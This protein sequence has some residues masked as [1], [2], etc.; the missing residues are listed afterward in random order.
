MSAAPEARDPSEAAARPARDAAAG[1]E[2][3]RAKLLH[4]PLDPAA[5]PSLLP[6]PWDGLDWRLLAPYRTETKPRVYWAAD[7]PRRVVCK[8]ISAAWRRPFIGRFRR[9][10]LRNEVAALSALDGLPGLPRL[11]AH[12]P[13]GMACEFV[14]GR[15][16]TDWD[17]G[18]VP[19]AVFD[20]L[21]GLLAAIHARHVLVADLHRRNILVTDEGEVHLVDF[22]LALDDR[23]GLGRLLAAR[24]RRLDRL[25]AARQRQ[26]HGAPLTPEH[27]DLLER[28]PRSERA[29]RSLKRWIRAMRRALPPRP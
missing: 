26:Y 1:T 3:R 14:P 13:S 29:L 17:R 7:G 16:L 21:D 18:S 12:W 28:R 10:A 11:L 25:N 27:R 4:R 5:R 15:M 20:R 9:W 8:D 19:A 23:R 24:L 2:R 22:E 6:P